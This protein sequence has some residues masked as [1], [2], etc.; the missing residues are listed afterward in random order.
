MKLNIPE[1]SNAMLLAL[2]D[3]EE[4]AAAKWRATAFFYAGNPV[5]HEVPPA[6]GL[7]FL[8]FEAGRKI[9]DGWLKRIGH[10]DPADELRVSIVE[11]PIP[12]DPS[13]YTVFISTNP[14]AAQD[15]T[16][17]RFSQM[18]RMNPAP[19]SPHLRMFKDHFAKVKRYRLF[20]AEFDGTRLT[21]LDMSRYI[22]KHQLNLLHTSHLKPHEMEYSVFNSAA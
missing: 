8:D 7:A 16:F 4:W 20:P 18:N 1:L 12:A 15:G 6:L 11:G 14:L 3:P 19:G 9:F 21:R 5:P 22:E 13:G 17:I 10:L 2:T